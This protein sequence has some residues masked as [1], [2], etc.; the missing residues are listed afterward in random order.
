MPRWTTADMR[1]VY[2]LNT[3]QDK[4]ANATITQHN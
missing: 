3:L 1:R 4:L 2:K